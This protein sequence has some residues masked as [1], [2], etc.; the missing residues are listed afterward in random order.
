MRFGGN[1]I[2]LVVASIVIFMIL[3]WI[4][5]MEIKD[6]V[7]TVYG[8]L[9]GGLIGYKVSKF[10]SEKS[11]KE[12]KKEFGFIVKKIHTV[13]EEAI[14]IQRATQRFLQH[15]GI[16]TTEF[17][18]DGKNLLHKETCVQSIGMDA[19][20]EDKMNMNEMTDDK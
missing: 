11:S 2:I 13:A 19:T 16:S 4:T 15:S 18:N 7:S 17:I 8:V 10:Y 6:L 5:N 9:I 12:L 3:A 1:D 14:K 20:R